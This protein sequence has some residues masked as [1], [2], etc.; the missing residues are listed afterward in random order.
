MLWNNITPGAHL[1]DIVRFYRIIDFDFSKTPQATNQIKAYRPRIEHCL[2]FTPFDDERAD[3]LHGKSYQQKVVI[4]GQHTE[5]TYR[6]VGK[7]FLNFQVVFQ[8]GVLASFLKIS[9]EELSNS[10]LDA[11]L[12]LG[13]D[14]HL[15]N[16]RLSYCRSYPEMIAV[17]E[18]FL[19]L[20][21]KNRKISP[22]PIH[23]IAQHLLNPFQNNKIEWYAGQA[24]LCYRQFDRAFK[25]STGITPKDYQSLVKLDLAYLLRNRFPDKDWFSIA[26][27]SGF[28]DYQHLSKHYKRYTGY[29]PTEFYLL[30]QNAPERHFGD[31]EH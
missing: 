27:E 26:I 11:G 4:F 30:E 2:Q 18:E 24:N 28:Y 9:A 13:A 10:Y 25:S 31:F 6:K 16:E 3:Y 12:F 20:Y 19:T 17:V 14:M 23:Q 21:L 22:H 15:V 29:S 5:L 1:N 8:P 7:R